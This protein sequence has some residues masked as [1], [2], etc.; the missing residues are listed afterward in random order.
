MQIH[1]FFPQSLYSGMV[2]SA[3]LSPHGPF[4]LNIDYIVLPLQ[5]QGLSYQ[6]RD[7]MF[8]ILKYFLY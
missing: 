7:L 2:S 3:Q 8:I 6:K 1:S 5:M 4:L